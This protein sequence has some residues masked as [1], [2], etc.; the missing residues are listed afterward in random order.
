MLQRILLLT[1]VFSTS[2]VA[3]SY[4]SAQLNLERATLLQL[5]NQFWRFTD[6]VAETDAKFEALRAAVRDGSL[7]ASIL[8]DELKPRISAGRRRWRDIETAFDEALK[9]KKVDLQRPVQTLKLPLEP[10]FQLYVVFRKHN[11]FGTGL[12]MEFL[13]GA[14]R[15]L[16][17]GE[18]LAKPPQNLERDGK[19]GRFQIRRNDSL[20]IMT[21]NGGLIRGRFE[22]MSGRSYI[23][24][25]I[26]PVAMARLMSAKARYRAFNLNQVARIEVIRQPP[27]LSLQDS[28]SPTISEDGTYAPYYVQKEFVWRIEFQPSDVELFELVKSGRLSEARFAPKISPVDPKVDT[29]PRF[30]SFFFSD[31]EVLLG[32]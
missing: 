23:I 19:L 28:P 15:G 18:R 9:R 26:L 27:G 32:K 29:R 7:E 21:T 10:A 11:R 3:A 2:P 20:L 22:G 5:Q 17:I 14:A 4:S 24:R 12:H 30:T 6:S 16:K 25:E 8:A 13:M 1:L 31:C